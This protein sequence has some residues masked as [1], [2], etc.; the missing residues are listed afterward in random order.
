MIFIKE[1]GLI[2]GTTMAPVHGYQSLY[3]PKIK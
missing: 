2:L 1:S 3:K